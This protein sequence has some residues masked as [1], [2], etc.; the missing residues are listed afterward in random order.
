MVRMIDAHFR[1][2][3]GCALCYWMVTP[4]TVY[5]THP[6]SPQR[7]QCLIVGR[8]GQQASP[9]SE[10]PGFRCPS[11]AWISVKLYI[12]HLFS[13]WLL[14]RVPAC[15]SQGQAQAPNPRWT[16]VAQSVSSVR[17]GQNKHSDFGLK[18]KVLLKYPE[19]WV[20]WNISSI[21]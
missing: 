10:Y 11:R 1:L 2:P 18:N 5:I 20:S 13:W 19:G 21:T 17:T 15:E 4:R 3:E 6:I 14:F 16:C 9:C 7:A 8:Q 12:C